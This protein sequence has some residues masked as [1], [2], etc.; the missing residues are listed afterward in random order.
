MLG[1]WEEAAKDL[2]LASKLDYDEEIGAVLKKVRLSV[3]LVCQVIAF[4]GCI[5]LC[6]VIHR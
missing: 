1:H 3:S 4:F 6:C 5:Y 2:H